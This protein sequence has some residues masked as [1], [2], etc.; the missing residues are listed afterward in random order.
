[1]PSGANLEVA[2]DA[3]VVRQGLQDLAADIPKIGRLGI[4]RTAQRII[5]RM[6]QPGAAIGYPVN[7]DSDRQ[8]I[9][10]FASDGFGSGVPAGRSGTYQ[11]SWHATQLDNGYSIEND[12]PEALYIGGDELGQG[13]SSIH[14]GRWPLL[15][16]VM[17]Q[18]IGYLDDDVQTEL[19]IVAADDGIEIGM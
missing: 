3:E 16:N 2:F 19:R 9:A 18:E 6:K 13:Q 4:Y 17:E 14:Q 8:R 5:K 10:F 7:W 1:M 11:E 12:S 15:F